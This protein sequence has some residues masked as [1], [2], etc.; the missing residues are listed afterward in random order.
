MYKT[1]SICW[2]GTFVLFWYF[3]GVCY[4]MRKQ[5]HQ[6]KIKRQCQRDALLA[7]QLFI[8][9]CLL[10]LQM[11]CFAKWQKDTGSRTRAVKASSY[12]RRHFEYFMQTL[13]AIKWTWLANTCNELA[14]G[15]WINGKYCIALQMTTAAE[16]YRK[17]KWEKQ[18]CIRN[19][20]QLA[21][22]LL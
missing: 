17:I 1:N 6:L 11:V 21:I 15:Q 8:A 14:K 2:Y 5:Q 22:I 9:Y 12:P 13:L 18:N 10:F 7:G 4:V 20:I 16:K 3:A 19:E